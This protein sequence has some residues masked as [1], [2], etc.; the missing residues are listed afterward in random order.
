MASA[1]TGRLTLRILTPTRE[2][3]STEADSVNLVAYEGEVGILPGHAP[4]LAIV[5]P[6][7][8]TVKD[9]ATSTRYAL[10][11]GFLEVRDDVMT[12]L[13]RAAEAQGDVDT[14][15]A[16]RRLAECEEKLKRTDLSE[17]ERAA[18]EQ[19]REKQAARLALAGR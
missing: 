11:D 9:G 12:V 1:A 4:Y 3:V 6:G 17:D 7:I 10:G 18:A 14:A 8:A 13:V 16:E 15:R 2:L 19:S 5:R